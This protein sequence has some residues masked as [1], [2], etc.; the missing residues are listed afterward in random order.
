VADSQ[1][2]G[3]TLRVQVRTG[4]GEL[5]TLAGSDAAA[6][7]KTSRIGAAVNVSWPRS[8]VIELEADPA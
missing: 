6:D 1:Y 5:L 4:S 7:Q 8:S 3:A 2:H